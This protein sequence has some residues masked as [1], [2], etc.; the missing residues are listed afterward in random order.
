M[1]V[2][3][4]C[5]S[6]TLTFTGPYSV[7]SQKIEQHA[8]NVGYKL[9]GFAPNGSKCKILEFGMWNIA[10]NTFSVTTKNMINLWDHVQ[11]I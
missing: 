2:E 7:T 4:T 5:S 8:G 9:R 1:K 10:W 6:E 3:A 11:K